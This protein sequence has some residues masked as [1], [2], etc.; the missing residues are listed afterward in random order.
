M[1]DG[2]SMTI[3][4]LRDSANGTFDTL[5]DYLPITESPKA[6]SDK[7]L[8]VSNLLLLAHCWHLLVLVPDW[9]FDKTTNEYPPNLGTEVK[10]N[11]Q[12]LSQ[13]IKQSFR[14]LSNLGSNGFFSPYGNLHGAASARR[15]TSGCILAEAARQESA[16]SCCQPLWAERRG[17]KAGSTIKRKLKD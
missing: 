6:P 5:D 14:Q 2:D 4:N 1:T 9:R 16:Y 10:P 7:H 3:N 13:S 8:C 15:S 12:S 11:T 17:G